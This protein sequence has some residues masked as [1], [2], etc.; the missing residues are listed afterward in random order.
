MSEVAT[1]SKP[2][3]TPVTRKVTKPRKLTPKQKLFV[4]KYTDITNKKTFGNGTQSALVAYNTTKPEVAKEIGRDNLLSPSVQSYIEQLNAA[5][6]NSIEDRSTQL[7]RYVQGL[8][9]NETV[10][11]Q[12]AADGTTLVAKTVVRKDVPASQ[13]LRAIDL[14]N[15]VEGIYNRANVQEHVAK[16]AYDER[17]RDLREAMHKRLQARNVTPSSE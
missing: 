7:A 5:N 9:H 16:R 17:M 12:Y 8:V 3:Q 1:D 6:H 2:S 14:S 15:K 13:V 4:D 10:T 11:N